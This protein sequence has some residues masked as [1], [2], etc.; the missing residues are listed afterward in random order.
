MNEFL[1][2]ALEITTDKWNVKNLL[3]YVYVKN[4][5]Y[6]IFFLIQGS[7]IIVKEFSG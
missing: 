1:F 2:I 7:M 5:F 6:S 4:P 3:V